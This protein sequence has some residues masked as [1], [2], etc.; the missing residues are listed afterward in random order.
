MGCS[1]AGTHFVGNF[2]DIA[3]VDRLGRKYWEGV[4][5][6]MPAMLG[7]FIAGVVRKDLPV[8]RLEPLIPIDLSADIESH[9]EIPRGRP[10]TWPRRNELRVEMIDLNAVDEK[11]LHTQQA[12]AVAGSRVVGIL[13]L[14]DTF[15]VEKSRGV[16][17]AAVVV[18]GGVPG[19]SPTNPGAVRSAST[20]QRL[21]ASDAQKS[22]AVHG[23]LLGSPRPR[24]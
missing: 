18:S 19:G 17:S 21:W 2:V 12:I 13:D 15:S 9:I 22:L 10:A 3:D 16:T 11:R 7:T 5:T 4:L 23:R 20:H 24:R 8:T 14:F 1:W 6:N